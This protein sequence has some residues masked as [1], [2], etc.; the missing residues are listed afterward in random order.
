MCSSYHLIHETTSVLIVDE[1]DRKA[2]K[3]QINPRMFRSVRLFSSFPSILAWWRS[4]LMVKIVRCS[5]SAAFISR[6]RRNSVKRCK[7][8]KG[9]DRRR[10][11]RREGWRR[12]EHLSNRSM[13]KNKNGTDRK[14]W[15][16]GTNTF[17]LISFFQHA[18]L[19]LWW[20]RCSCF[21]F[22]GHRF[23]Y[24]CLLFQEKSLKEELIQQAEQQKKE[25]ERK[26]ET[27]EKEN[28]A[29]LRRQNERGREGPVK[30]VSSAGPLGG[31]QSNYWQG[32]TRTRDEWINHVHTVLA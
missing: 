6:W 22:T 25:G 1:E 19:V 15:R 12:N 13:K 17:L 20:Y 23:L 18:V 24:D 4:K 10:R 2:P 29:A 27:E 5:H 14:E 11:K 3:N 21:C 30:E 28:A 26:K 8:G 16:W 31:A 7:R 9:L 32:R